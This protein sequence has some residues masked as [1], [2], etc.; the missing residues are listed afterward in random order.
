MHSNSTIG[1]VDQTAIDQLVDE[2]LFG[3]AH[4]QALARRVLRKQAEEE[5]IVLRSLASLNRERAA[6]PERFPFTVPAMNVRGFGYEFCRAVI[7]AARRL[8]C[9]AFIIEIARSELDY[10]DQRPDD[11]AVI[12]LAAALREGFVGPLFLQG[13]HFK[14]ARGKNLDKEIEALERLIEESLT[15]GFFNVDIDGSTL[16][17]LEK[18][19]V[20]EQQAQNAEVTAHLTRFIRRQPAGIDVNLGGEIGEIGGPVSTVEE[21]RAFMQAYQRRVSGD[22]ILK[23]A[24]QTGTSHGGTPNPDGSVKNLRVD[25]A[26]LKKLSRVAQAE[27]GLA[28][29]V[30]HGASTLSHDQFSRFPEVGCVEVHLSTEF[31]NTILDHPAFPTALRDE[32]RAYVES[33]FT[34]ERTPNQTDAQFFY[35]HRKRAWGP[36]KRAVAQLPADAR[37]AIMGALEEKVEFLFRTLRVQGTRRLVE[38]LVLGDTTR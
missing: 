13:D 26:T 1:K 12:A 17:D 36:F 21:L 9:G 10:T 11:V 4:H 16:I 37:Q 18:T 27:F 23:V 25:F 32:M 34:S 29:A 35:K 5:G 38:S 30:Q 2:A 14:V 3:H 33:H 19:S 20:A 15:A 8:D 6:T 28:G 31:Q 24:V 22:G 7:R